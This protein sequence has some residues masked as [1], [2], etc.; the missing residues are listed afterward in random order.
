MSGPILIGESNPHGG[1]PEMA[2]YPLPPESAGGRMQRLVLGLKRWRYVELD[3]Y[4]LC[5]G[6]WRVG[7]ARDGANQLMARNRG[8]VFL[9]LG[10]KV[11]HAFGEHATPAFSLVDRTPGDRWLRKSPAATPILEPTWI[12]LVLLPHPSGRNSRMWGPD[13]IARTRRLLRV[14]CAGMPCG[15]IG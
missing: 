9:L 3:R 4:N 11:A 12:R 1:D 14:V 13:N 7:T 10:R 2:L 8:R 5:V 15:E 6:N